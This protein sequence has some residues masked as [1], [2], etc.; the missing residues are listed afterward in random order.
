MKVKNFFRA[1]RGKIFSALRADGSALRASMHLP[2]HM[3]PIALHSIG[4]RPSTFLH[5]PPAACRPR[6]PLTQQS[7][8]ML[9]NFPPGCPPLQKKLCTA[10]MLFLPS[11]CTNPH[12]PVP[13]HELNS[14]PGCSCFVEINTS[15]HTHIYTGIVFELT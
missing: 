5:P 10:L 3:L 15:P 1:S 13:L 11:G 6:L 12:L 9:D 4:I 8:K 14:F 2:L 7:P